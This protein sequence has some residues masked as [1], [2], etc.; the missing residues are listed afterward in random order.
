MA[1]WVPFFLCWMMGTFLN[2]LRKV[3]DSS[4][5]PSPLHYVYFSVLNALARRTR[6]DYWLI[7]LW[8]LFTE[9]SVLTLEFQ[10]IWFFNNSGGVKDNGSSWPSFVNPIDPSFEED[11]DKHQVSYQISSSQHQ[12]KNQINLLQNRAATESWDSNAYNWDLIFL[13]LKF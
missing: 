7:W 8:A 3:S 9:F 4:L 6:L 12:N 5:G 1:Y 10:L 11:K 13:Y 2:T